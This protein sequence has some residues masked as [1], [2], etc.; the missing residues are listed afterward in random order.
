[1]QTRTHQYDIDAEG[2]ERQ[3]APS[4]AV[5]RPDNIEMAREVALV[6]EIPVEAMARAME[7]MR[8]F[9]RG[10]LKEGAHY[11]T[12]PGIEKPFLMLPGAE[13]IFRA[14]NCRP[15]YETVDRN[16]NPGDPANSFIWRK[17]RAV[18][19]STGFVM[20]EADA[21][22]MAEEFRDRYGRLTWAK[23]VPNM[24]MRADKRAF[25][26]AARTL[27][28][29]SE[30][31]TQDEDLVID[32]PEPQAAQAHHDITAR[33]SPPEQRAPAAKKPAPAAPKPPKGAPEGWGNEYGGQWWWVCPVHGWTRARLWPANDRGPANLSCQSRSEDGSYCR[34]RVTV[35][36]LNAIRQAFSPSIKP[37]PV[38]EETVSPA[39]DE[40]FD[41]LLEEED[42]DEANY[43]EVEE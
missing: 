32:A 38:G 13:Q 16:I 5:A 9:V 15:E 39:S 40:E 31:F 2:D 4:R 22:C 17:C 18:N 11:G 3:L 7:A 33:P 34:Q 10:Q 29:T 23:V 35:Q 42:V 14:F 1:M 41:K 43:V 27:G 20:G 36:K 21:I 12:V 8:R 28:A 37:V 19:I 30:F 24:L 6:E 25:V 26:K